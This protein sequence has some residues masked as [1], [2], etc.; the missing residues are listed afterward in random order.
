MQRS[1]LAS[2]GRGFTPKVIGCGKGGQN[3]VPLLTRANEIS[4]TL[5]IPFTG[6]LFM[7]LKSSK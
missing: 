3:P 6:N 5:R 7:H 4:N 2:P 1:C